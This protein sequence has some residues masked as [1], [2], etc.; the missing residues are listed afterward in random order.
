VNLGYQTVQAAGLWVEEDGSFD[1]W[2]DGFEAA[3]EQGIVDRIDIHL[4]CR[5]EAVGFVEPGKMGTSVV[6]VGMIAD[7]VADAGMVAEAVVAGRIGMMGAY[8]E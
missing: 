3:A 2:R 4:G 1:T 7:A 5:D 8:V 6:A